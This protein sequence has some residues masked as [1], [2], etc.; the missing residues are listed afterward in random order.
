MLVG[1]GLRRGAAVFVMFVGAVSMAPD[2]DSRPAS[3]A[4]FACSS[5]GPTY[6]VGPGDSWYGIA[7]RA[8]VDPSS[9]LEVNDASVDDLLVVGDR[10]CLPGGADVSGIC[11]SYTV[12]A[13]D[14]W[15]SIS[16]RVGSTPTAVAG[17]NGV[18]TD[19]TIH[20]GEVVCLPPGASAPS[21]SSGSAVTSGG[22]GGSYTVVRN[23]SWSTIAQRAEVSMRSLLAANGAAA[24]DLLVPGDVLRLPAGAKQPPPRAASIVLEAA[25]TQG[26]CG[27]GD[28]WG[29]ARH[30]GRRHVGV[31]IFSGNGNYVYAVVDGRLSSRWWDGAG[32]RSGNAWML[33]G[34]DGN[35][36]FYAHLSGFPPQLRVGSRV[37]AG[38][39]IGWVGST[40]NSSAPHLHFEI[41]PGGGE[42]VNPHPIVRAQGACNSGR[43]YTQPGGWVPDRKR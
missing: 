37:Q 5:G 15:G 18:G 43:P 26:P 32:G 27:Y 16:V 23:D 2:A 24:G 35:K 20:P 40:G 31:D 1:A 22:S 13:G 4:G 33:T 38:Q 42:P 6:V 29:H 8:A 14:S 34:A 3:A 21:V 9:L 30:G 10:L 36:Y 25:P 41:R 19:H 7:G 39:I 17:A 28:T 12:R 11:T